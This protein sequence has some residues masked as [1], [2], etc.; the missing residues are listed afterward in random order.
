MVQPALVVIDNATG[1]TIPE[2]TWS[3]K[4]MNLEDG[5][6]ETTEVTPGVE[7]VAFRPVIS[8]IR[9]AIAERRRVKLASVAMTSAEIEEQ[10]KKYGDWV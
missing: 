9:A 5:Y 3:W 1:K 2:L 6:T 4:T 10:C 7:L 8:D